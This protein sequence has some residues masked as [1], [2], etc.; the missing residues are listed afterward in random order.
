MAN[1]QIIQGVENP[2]LVHSS[3]YVKTRDYRFDLLPKIFALSGYF[4]V[5]KMSRLCSIAECGLDNILDVSG[6]IVKNWA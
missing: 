4:V 2:G 1:I 6:N 5:D 3:T